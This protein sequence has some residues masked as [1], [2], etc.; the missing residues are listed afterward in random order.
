MLDF[1]KILKQEK[2]KDYYIEL[3]KFVDSEYN[4]KNIFP[5]KENIFEIYA[6]PMGT[7][8]DVTNALL[9]HKSIYKRI[10]KSS[11]SKSVNEKM[12]GKTEKSCIGC[13]I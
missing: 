8:N 5:P 9:P 1:E 11:V 7:K 12:K 10:V 6:N 2:E 13:G 3:M 4:S